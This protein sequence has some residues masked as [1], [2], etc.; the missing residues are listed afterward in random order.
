MAAKAFNSAEKTETKTSY[1]PK[2]SKINLQNV[3][4][5]PSSTINICP[6]LSRNG[7]PLYPQISEVPYQSAYGISMIWKL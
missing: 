1:K 3:D 6:E 2:L 7:I 5:P 4:C